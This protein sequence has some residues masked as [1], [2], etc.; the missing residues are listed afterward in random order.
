MT[1]PVPAVFGAPGRPEAPA[2]RAGSSA[3]E[4][5]PGESAG[6]SDDKLADVVPLA[7]FDAREEAR[8]WW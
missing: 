6:Q 4:E 1:T 5:T 3:P 7:V 8:R 2:L